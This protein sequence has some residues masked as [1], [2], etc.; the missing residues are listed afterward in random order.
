MKKKIVF[1]MANLH[2]G[3]AERV[4]ANI[5][6]LLDKDK[7]D[8]KLLMVS[9]EGPFLEEIPSYVDI[10]N[11]DVKKTI[12]S[13]FKLRTFIKE[14]KP[15]II[16]STLFH[17]SIA[18]YFALKFIDKK[19]YI[20]ARNPTSPKLLVEEG[21]SSIWKYFL[22]K[23]YESADKIL[24][25]TPE[26][27][28][29]I[30]QYYGVAKEKIDIL[31]NPLD[32]ES[33]DKKIKSIDNPFDTNKINVVSAGRLTYAK[34]FDTLL[35]AF[36]EVILENNRFRLHIIGRNDGEGEKIKE[37]CTKLALNEYV[38]FLG[39][40]SNPYKYYYYSDLY[41][42]SSRREGLP[43]TVLENLY[44]NKPIVAT[45]CIPFMYELIDE[46]KN[47]YIVD[48]DNVKDMAKAIL[49]YKKLIYTTNSKK[50][51]NNVSNY[52]YG[53]EV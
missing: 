50:E 25:Q 41:V 9:K 18:V 3:G 4:T 33:I 6:K 48:V 37:L 46:N 38:Q 10:I 35:Y 2:S 29:E 5:I 27:K 14:F 23:S 7:F 20:L 53:F 13:I 47:G 22:E 19:P 12:L 36:K 44:L 21:L 52:F 11:M 40:Q 30:S 32:T 26:M 39:F 1:F 28:N 49:N 8:I 16:Y 42:L 17:T 45:N 43:N 34:A 31:I 51:E 15:D 24:A